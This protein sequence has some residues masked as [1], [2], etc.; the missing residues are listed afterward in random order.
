MGGEPLDWL[1]VGW[2]V[3]V[4]VRNSGKKDKYYV[5]PSNGRRFNSKPEVLRYV[6]SSVK[7]PN[8]KELSKINIEKTVTENLP[9]GWIKEIRTKKKGGRTRRD[10]CYIDPVSGRHFRSMQEV[11]RYLESKDVRNAESKPDEKR[12]VSVELAGHSQ[13][14]SSLSVEVDK[15]PRRSSK[16]LA[17]VEVDKLEAEIP[18]N[19]KQKNPIT[20]EEPKNPDSCVDDLLTDP[21]IE[22]AVKTLTGAITVE[23]DVKKVGESSTVS[24]IWADP[25]FEFAVKTLTGD[26][27]L[28]DASKFR[29]SLQQTVNMATKG[30]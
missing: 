25:C 30:E 10:P 22:F 5:N 3:S 28:E 9:P 20:T 4:K 15:L 6:K 27:P 1:P 12:H 23:E 21:C 11:F 2:R 13:S 26:M 19:K 17:R 18:T 24:S 8:P 14:V 29:V 16:R 7:N